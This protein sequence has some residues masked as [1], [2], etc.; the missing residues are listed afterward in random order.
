MERFEPLYT[1]IDFYRN[2]CLNRFDCCDRNRCLPQHTVKNFGQI[3][4]KKTAL[5]RTRFFIVIVWKKLLIDKVGLSFG[6][7]FFL[8]ARIHFPV[9]NVKICGGD[10][11]IVL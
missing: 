8:G 7:G 4:M 11:N 9:R 5:L 3:D 1:P 6:V 10:E 2:P